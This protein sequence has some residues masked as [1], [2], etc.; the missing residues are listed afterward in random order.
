M[1][2]AK[3]D[4]P[5]FVLAVAKSNSFSSAQLVLGDIHAAVLRQIAACRHG[6][7]AVIAS[8]PQQPRRMT[9]GFVTT[10]SEWRVTAWPS[11]V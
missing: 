5:R 3:R 10:T 7:N 6:H 4:E 9:S 1:H 8:W 11:G 2:N